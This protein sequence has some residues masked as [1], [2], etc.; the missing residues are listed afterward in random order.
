MP[1][2]QAP[3][4]QSVERLTFNEDVH[5]SSPCGRTT[6]SL[7]CLKVATMD[8]EVVQNCN[9]KYENFSKFAFNSKGTLAFWNC[10]V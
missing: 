6:N 2:W 4:A 8:I 10:F 3:I 7:I 5:G 1:L 9:V